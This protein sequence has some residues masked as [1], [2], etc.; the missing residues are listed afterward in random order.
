MLTIEPPLLLLDHIPSDVLAP[1]PLPENA[2]PAPAP[3][4]AVIISD[5]HLGSEN[6]QAKSITAFLQQILDAQIRTRRL[7]INGDV[8]DSID[9]RRLKK[10]HWKVLSQIRHLSD[11]IDV[12]WI[13]GNHD[14]PAEI[15]S[16]LLGVSVV[17]EFTLASG[18][19]DILIIHGHIFDDFIEDHPILTWCADCIYFLMQKIDRTHYVARLAKR[20]S[21]IFIRC[22]DKIRR[23]A[24]E[25]AAKKNCDA[26]ICGHTHHA[27]ALE[28]TPDNP[29]AYYNSGCWTESPSSYIQIANGAVALHRYAAEV[30]ANT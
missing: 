4:D 2:E 24:R 7:I 29:I 28:P 9:F 20:K 17:E 25:L 26:V 27:E 14:G 16:H 1:P 5:L 3:L 19:R 11:K 18:N 13:V 6:C 8:F 15:V 12:V 22:T 10:T 21:K 30:A 23:R